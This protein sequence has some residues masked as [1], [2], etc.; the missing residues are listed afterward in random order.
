M[1]LNIPEKCN[2]KYYLFCQVNKTKLGPIIDIGGGLFERKCP[3]CGQTYQ[4]RKITEKVT[5]EQTQ[6][7]LDQYPWVFITSSVPAKHTA[8]MWAK[9][10]KKYIDTNW[11]WV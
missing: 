2:G 4:G 10:Y 11:P 9:G 3:I 6:K 8:K 7:Q 5:P 1:K